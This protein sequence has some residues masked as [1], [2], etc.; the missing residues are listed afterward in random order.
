MPDLTAI[1]AALGSL[2]LATEIA[3][4]LREGNATLQKAELKL[5]LAELAD[6]LAE[7]KLQ[8]VEVREEIV[9]RD[10]RIRQLEEAFRSKES[11]VRLND[12]YYEVGENGEAYGDPYCVR[13]WEV[14][15]LQYRLVS[16]QTDRRLK[17]CPAC[18]HKYNSHHTERLPRRPAPSGS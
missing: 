5:R 1:N 8:V 16:E 9:R 3:K 10:E 13:C 6:A 18:G 17:Q 4:I 15:H 11:L 14:D 7:A 2:K 12:A